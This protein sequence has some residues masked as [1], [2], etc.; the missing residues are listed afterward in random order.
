MLAQPA[1]EAQVDAVGGLRFQQRVADVIVVAVLAIQQRRH[2]LV[3]VGT[4]QAAGQRDIDAG[5]VV[6]VPFQVQRGQQ[7]VVVAAG[8]TFGLAVL[9]VADVG[10]R[11]LV[12]QAGFPGEA[13][14]L[15]GHHHVRIDAGFLDQRTDAVV[16]FVDHRIAFV[17]G[18][19]GEVGVGDVALLAAP[20]QA[21]LQFRSA[22]RARMGQSEAGLLVA[23]IHRLRLGLGLVP[24]AVDVFVLLFALGAGVAETRVVE[25]EFGGAAGHL[26]TVVGAQPPI[27]LPDRI[28][29]RHVRF[30]HVAVVVLDFVRDLGDIAF[31]L[32]V[33][34]VD[35]ETAGL[36]DVGRP[37]QVG[38][39]IATVLDLALVL[40]ASQLVHGRVGKP[41][42]ALQLAA[43][44]ILQVDAGQ[45]APA[46][47]IAAGDRA[48][49]RVDLAVERAGGTDA[50]VAAVEHVGIAQDDVDGA[51]HRVTAAVGAVAAQD[52]DVVDHLRGDAV[53]PERAVIARTRHL[54]AV[55]QH[56]GVT[57]GHAA[58]H[59]AVEL[60][61]VGADE[62][63]AGH[64]LEH[65]ADRRRLEALE[66]FQV[67]AQHRRGVFGAVAV[68]DLGLDHD[69][70]QV[71]R[72]DGG[73]VGGAAAIRRDLLRGGEAGRQ[74]CHAE[75]GA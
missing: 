3:E 29:A 37:R 26:E 60:H 5:R 2:K 73:Q 48:E 55:D 75:Q 19:P 56:L 51:G 62:G 64:A 18:F 54:L 65:V 68:G 6:E 39:R 1:L 21:E 52:L 15:A 28:Q 43:I 46:E 4:L 44:A 47:E 70:V 7:H 45:D 30:D 27:R 49:A 42:G 13:V 58:H 36:A 12:A 16:E 20:I 34:A 32:D 63:H 71:L 57:G 24:I 40:E 50:H 9:A 67:E 14:A 38:R 72:V 8:R 61:D 74:Q 10:L 35:A 41:V 23:G 69:L 31:G 11:G 66:I 59:R 53:D 25:F 17:L 33:E 22:D